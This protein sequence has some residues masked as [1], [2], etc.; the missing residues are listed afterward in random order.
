MGFEVAELALNMLFFL[1]MENN[2]H[3]ESEFGPMTVQCC[4]CKRVRE[5]QVWVDQ[6]LSE[7][8]EANTSHGYCPV[9]AAKA[10]AEIHAYYA[11]K[12]QDMRKAASF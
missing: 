10:F 3:R 5:G 4:I 1:S 9:C 8:E 2:D 6:V 7:Q 12:G 11:Q